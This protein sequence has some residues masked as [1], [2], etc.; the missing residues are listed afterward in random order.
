[1][2]TKSSTSNV[3]RSFQSDVAAIREAP[4]PRS[5][6]MTV[7]VLWGFLVV[8]GIILWLGKIDRIVVSQAGQ[9]DLVGPPAVYQELD[10]SI[11]KSIDVR[12]GMIVKKGQ[13][14]ATLDPTFT[15]ADLTQLK[16]QVASL[17]AQILRDEAELAGKVPVF[18]GNDDPDQ[19]HYND[20]QQKLF[21]DRDAQYKAQ[22]KSFDEQIK[23]TEATIVKT[24]N[25]I[26]RYAERA[27]IAG[28]IEGMGSKLL[29]SGA[30]S[31]LTALQSK[32][33]SLEMHRLAEELTN[34]LKESEAQLDTLKAN[35]EAFIQ[36]W[37]STDSQDLVTAQNT[38]DQAVAS[39]EK[40]QK[41][42]DLVKMVALDDSFILNVMKL[43]VGSVLQSGDKLI[44]AM[45]LNQAIIADLQVSTR[46]VGFI[47]VGDP[48]V[49]KIDAFEYT[50]HGTAEGKVVWISEGA[51][52]IDDNTGQPTTP[53]YKVGV[54]I[55]KT[56]FH[57]VPPNVRLVPGM[58]LTGD[59][60]V[61][62]RP[63][64]LYLLEG[65]IRGW[66]EAMREP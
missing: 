7:H 42:Q 48:V 9:I 63:A 21:T 5:A 15:Q 38:R 36:Q 6:M 27:E 65:V 30:G 43:S 26:G 49:L 12:E 23:Q 60:N 19:R 29:A 53:Y 46:D 59:I 55:E 44:T 3:V 50:M 34:A 22:I 35:K 32:D 25:D 47:R 4:P 62:K 11:I 17:N 28:K 66:S 56:N 2:A 54:S 31:L 39:L 1:M 52:W 33:Q 40:A 61:G 41:H 8:V 13:V 18:T 10:Q 37:R 20:L 64:G 14:L 45:P 16:Q 24:Q 58:T 51:F 57:G